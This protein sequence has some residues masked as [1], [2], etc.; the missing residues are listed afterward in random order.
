MPFIKAR[1]MQ[2]THQVEQIITA[3][4]RN[5]ISS[6]RSLARQPGGYVHDTLRK[7]VWPILLH[8]HY[9]CYVD[10]KGSEKDLADPVQIT[11]DV[12]RSLYYYPQDISPMLKAHKQQELHRMIVEILW[13]NPRLKYYQASP[14]EYAMLDSFD[15]VSKQLRLMSSIIEYEDPE[16]TSFL[17][18]SNIMPYYALSWILT[19]YSHDFEDFSKITR[20]FDLFVASSPLMPVYV[21]SAITLLRRSTIL[22]AEPDLAHSIISHIPH[23]INIDTVIQKAVSLEERYSALELQKRSG[24]WLHDESVVN[25]WYRDWSHMG[26]NDV[27]DSIKADRYLSHGIPKEEWEDEMLTEWMERRRK[28]FG[29]IDL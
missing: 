28:W 16:L 29:A 15:P 14:I 9:G 27:P 19:W 24:I 10:E 18:R 20:L 2:R 7:L 3:L 23:D 17:E 1:S 12:E 11:K 25:T 22:R 21:A 8:A 6:L 13:R 26:W 4:S 5:D